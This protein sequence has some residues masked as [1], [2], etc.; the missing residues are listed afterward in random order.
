MRIAIIS[1]GW[2]CCIHGGSEKF[3]HRLAEEFINLGHRVTAVTMKL[4]ESMPQQRYPLEVIDLGKYNL[5]KAIQFSRLAA[6]CVAELNSDI[7]I[8]NSYW[9]ELSPR[10]ISSI[11][12]IMVIHDIGFLKNVKAHLRTVKRYILS[13]SAKHSKAIVTP[14]ETVKNDLVR[15]LKLDP[16][17]IQVIGFE[18]VDGPF[19]REHKENAWFDIVQVARF[20]PNK[21]QLIL[22]D[23]FRKVVREVP[24]AKLWL[25]GSSGIKIKQRVYLEEVKHLASEINNDMGREVVRVVVDAP[26][27]DVY[28]RIADVC[29]APS[30]GEE[31]YGLTVVECM[32]YGKP[33][34]ASDIFVETGVVNEDRAYI[35]PRGNADKLAE[36]LLYVYRNY[37]EALRKADRGLEYARKCSWRKVAEFF[38][39]VIDETVS[40]R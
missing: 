39:K 37:S 10:F 32:A 31:G 26:N 36:L 9:S 4:C 34:I 20:A 18:G 24:S 28:Y 40:S 5:V 27:V 35:F 23:A 17:K 30:I 29:V 6:K 7:V 14:T 3:M 1:R 11:P 25:V 12:T 19:H 8:V 2:W 38:L 21:G 33:V 13:L 16:A 15:Y 22:I